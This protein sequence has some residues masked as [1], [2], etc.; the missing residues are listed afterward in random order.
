MWGC[1]Y[2]GKD[3]HFDTDY[4]FLSGFKTIDHFDI[5]VEWVVKRQGWKQRDQLVVY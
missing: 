5:H 4:K 3:I 2:Y 1:V